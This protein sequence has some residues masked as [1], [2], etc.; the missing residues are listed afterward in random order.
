MTNFND[1]PHPRVLFEDVSDELY[2]QLAPM[3]AH[4]VRVESGESIHLNEY[5]LL[6]TFASAV[7]R[8]APALN[9]MSVGATSI[10][11]FRR[12]TPI[13]ASHVDVPGETGELSTLANETI[14]PFLPPSELKHTWTRVAES[15]G[16]DGGIAQPVTKRR[17]YTPVPLVTIGKEGK[18]IAAMLVPHTIEG[19]E[20]PEKTW[21]VLPTETQ[22]IPRWLAAFLK[23]LHN[24][25][26]ERFPGVPNW[27]NSDDW[28]SSEAAQA[29]TALAVLRGAWEQKRA[30][31]DRQEVELQSALDSA[32]ER[33][34]TGIQRL[35]T[36][37]GDDLC[38]AVAAALRELG[39]TVTPMDDLHDAK[40]GAKLEDFRATTP[41]GQGWIA[42]G[43]VKGYSKGAKVNDLSQVT[44]RPVVNYVRETGVEP[45]SLWHIVN[46]HRGDDPSARAKAI[47]NDGELEDLAKQDGALIDTRDLFRAVRAVTAGVADAAAVRDSLIKA[48]RRWTFRL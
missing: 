11:P 38:D 17:S 25:D 20:R 36:A 30:E 41:D 22:E 14:G 35:L 8:D 13:L 23:V 29:A 9:V 40:T 39:F 16:W 43:E 10:G 4:A 5:D 6:V 24:S 15:S 44:N 26:A 46:V 21:L 3:V 12:A 45:G 18:E 37:N 42:L 28:S 27:S 2:V 34:R 7:K 32:R 1:Y 47:L 19:D 33:G 31:F 48:R